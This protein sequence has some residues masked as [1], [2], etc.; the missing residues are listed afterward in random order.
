MIRASDLIGC[1][2][3]TESGERVGRVHDLRAERRNGEWHLTELVLGRRGLSARLV[4][5]GPDRL[6]SGEVVDWDAVRSLQDGLVVVSD[7]TRGGRG[8]NRSADTSY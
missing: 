2:L 8:R 7:G 1:E 5:T 3:R 6:I 4:G